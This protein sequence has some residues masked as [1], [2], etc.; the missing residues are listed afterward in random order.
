[1]DAAMVGER[2]AAALELAERPTVAAAAL[3]AA[4]VR[5]E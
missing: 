2:L 5:P 4:Y 3:Q 1:M